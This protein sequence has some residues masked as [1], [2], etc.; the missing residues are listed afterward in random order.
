MGQN[1][2]GLTPSEVELLTMMAEEAAEV[3]Q[4]CT[5]ALRHGLSSRHPDGGPTNAQDLTRELHEL[6]CLSAVAH[7]AAVLEPSRLEHAEETLARKLRY[8]HNQQPISASW[9]RAVD[10]LSGLSYPALD[11]ELSDEDRQVLSSF[12]GQYGDLDVGLP[13]HHD[14]SRR[15]FDPA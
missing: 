5:K 7:F 15:G 6:F 8:S 12:W 1:H 14:P 4:A 10:W 13:N 2:V 3:V 9:N 11:E